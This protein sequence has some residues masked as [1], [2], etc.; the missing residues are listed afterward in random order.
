MMETKRTRLWRRKQ[1][2]Q[3]FKARRSTMHLSS[4]S[5]TMLTVVITFPCTGLNW[6]RNHG[7]MPIVLLAPPA[8]VGCAVAWNMTVWRLNGKPGALFGNP[9]N[10]IGKHLTI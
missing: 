10:E 7:L 2:F 8:A 4:A 1:G 3:V 9:K 6:Q 5:V